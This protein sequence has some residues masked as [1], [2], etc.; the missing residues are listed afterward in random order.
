MTMYYPNPPF[1][2]SDSSLSKCYRF[3]YTKFT[4]YSAIQSEP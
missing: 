4:I 1:H 2:L 3:F